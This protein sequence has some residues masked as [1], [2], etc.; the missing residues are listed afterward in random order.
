[1][2]EI[3]NFFV[4][5]K[6]NFYSSNVSFLLVGQIRRNCHT[7][8]IFKIAK[9]ASHWVA[10]G[11]HR[12]RWG[13]GLHWGLHCPRCLNLDAAADSKRRIMLGPRPL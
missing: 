3:N 6:S 9:P 2:S 11:L 12:G 8:E 5:A 13:R 10:E 7:G 4:E 1:L